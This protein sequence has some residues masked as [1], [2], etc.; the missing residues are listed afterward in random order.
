MATKVLALNE[1][2]NLTWCTCPP[3]L[4]GRGRCNHVEHQL[5]NETSQDFIQRIEK[6]MNEMEDKTV[7]SKDFIEQ[8]DGVEIS[9]Q[10]YRMTEEEKQSLLKIEN[11]MQL[12]QNI[13][14]GYIELDEPLWN[15]MDKKYF[16][17]LSGIHMKNIKNVINEDSY[18]ILQSESSKYPEGKVVSEETKE[19]IQNK[20]EELG[21]KIEFG[22]GVKAMNEFAMNNY[23]WEATRDVYVLPYYMRIGSDDIDSDLTVAYKYMFRNRA[24]PQLQQKAYESLLNNNSMAANNARFTKGF[25]NK[26]LAD[27]FAGKGGV[28]RACLSGSSI[29]YSARSVITPNPDIKFGE[30]KV[31]PSVVV[32]IYKP[33]LLKQF[34]N[35]GWSEEEIDDYF[36]Q[37]RLPQTKVP[38]HIRQDLELRISH[39]RVIMNRQPSLH[40]LSLQSFVPKVSDNATTQIH[41]LYCD[42]YGA[43]FDGDTVSLYGINNDEIVSVADKSIDAKLNINLR[44]PRAQDKLAIM[45]NKDALFGLINILDKR[46]I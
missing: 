39:K 23:N 41:P 31:P 24:K 20:A 5:D 38:E 18:I 1:K 32:D 11:R 37:C 40:T 9:T 25:R 6:Q 16:S 8:K 42:G 14:G 3:E 13:E 26:S 34:A 21:M 7:N 19:A 29:P 36:G 15:D 22:T 46:S 28:F 43:D 35:E 45:P 12:D 4:R 2:G 44:K 30:I 17:E 10:P 33:T 27:E